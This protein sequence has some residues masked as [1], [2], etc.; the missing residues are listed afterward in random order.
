MEATDGK[1]D[2]AVATGNTLLQ[3]ADSVVKPVPPPPPPK[4]MLL[5]QEPQA[6]D[7]VVPAYPAWAEEQGV[8]SRVLVMVTIDAEGKVVDARIERTGGKDFDE[9]AL[10]AA[11]RTRYKAYVEGGKPL[12]AKFVVAYQFVL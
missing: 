3:K 11:K 9:A 4:P 2:L 1:G 10:A 5:D 6:L 12:P 7:K 8:T